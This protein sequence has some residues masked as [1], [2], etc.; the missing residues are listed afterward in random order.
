MSV[1]FLILSYSLSG[2]AEDAEKWVSLGVS[3]IGQH[4]VDTNSLQ[5]ISPD[6]IFNI[7]TKV[8]EK[9][10]A[11]AKTEAGKDKLPPDGQVEWVTTMTIDCKANIFSYTNGRKY[12]QGKLVGGFSKARPAEAIGVG[13]MPDQ[14]KQAY[15]PVDE[16][17]QDA[18]NEP[19][20]LLAVPLLAESTPIDSA[21]ETTLDEPPS[22]KIEWQSIG[23]SAIAEV[24]YDR[25]SI[26][27]SQDGSRFIAHTK[28]VPFTSNTND[29]EA[30]DITL[31][32]LSFDCNDHSF[33]VVRMSK[34][35][36]DQLVSVF[37]TPQPPANTDKIATIQT[38]A[39]K[40][41]K[42]SDEPSIP[43][44]P[45]QLKK[46]TRCANTLSQV[47]QL[48]NKIQ[49]DIDDGGLL[50]KQVKSYVKQIQQLT[51]AVKRDDCAIDGLD[52]FVE[53]VKSEACH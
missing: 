46:D 22:G 50:C 43:K 45:E 48:Q 13:S 39:N 51:K 32:T 30:G 1:L 49:K 4:E 42:A 19:S 26:R 35:K 17:A 7:T 37:D 2:Y 33:M 9:S 44:T 11:Q 12:D 16:P 36:D 31:S 3:D 25:K 24:F 40:F 14:L 38:L 47:E 34:L 52:S 15:C 5:W 10:Q 28:V 29:A 6:S 27:R 8:I 21:S 53:D 18:A 23:K 41:C 20:S